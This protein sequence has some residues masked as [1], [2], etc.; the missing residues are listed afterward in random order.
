MSDGK[1]AYFVPHSAAFQWSQRRDVDTE[2]INKV[3][4]NKDRSPLALSL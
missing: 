1:P 3:T 2:G 4:N